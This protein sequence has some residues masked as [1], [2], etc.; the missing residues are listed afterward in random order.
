MEKCDD[1]IRNLLL[2]AEQ[3]NESAQKEFGDCY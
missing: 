1:K 2:E 3:G